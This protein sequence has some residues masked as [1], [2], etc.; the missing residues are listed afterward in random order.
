MK[1]GR[2]SCI[3][4]LWNEDLYLFDVLNEISLVRNLDEVICVDDA[5]DNE[6]YLEIKK[7]FPKFCVIRL[8][9]N[10]GKTD[11]IRIGLEYAKGDYIMLIDADLQNLNHREIESAVKSMKSD[12]AIDMLILRR[13]KAD[14]LIRAYRGDVLFTGERI[15]KRSDLLEILKGPVKRWQLESAINTWMYQN[16]RKVFWTAQSATNTNKAL[17]WG[18]ISG[19]INNLR[20]FS[21]MMFANGFRNFLRQILYYA[22][23]ELKIE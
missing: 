23:D 18:L 12:P 10:S 14:L 21:D 2:T 17:K 6:N 22:K 1:Q 3:I 16:R 9:E 13:V 11:A 5:S 7:R 19:I 4:P 15:I 20:T 8:P